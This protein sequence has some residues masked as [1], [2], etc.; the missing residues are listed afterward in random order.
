MMF[1]YNQLVNHDDDILLKWEITYILTFNYQR[2][3]I[4]YSHFNKNSTLIY[5]GSKNGEAYSTI[6]HELNG[7]SKLNTIEKKYYLDT[8]EVT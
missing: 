8:V 1:I 4:S 3:M 7:K 5:N 6:F 2:L